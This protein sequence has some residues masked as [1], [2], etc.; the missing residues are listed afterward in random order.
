[1]L[2][3]LVGSEMCIRDRAQCA[4][5]FLPYVRRGND[6]DLCYSIPVSYL[7]ANATSPNRLRAASY[8]EP[9]SHTPDNMDEECVVAYV[10]CPA[11]FDTFLHVWE[12][13]LRPLQLLHQEHVLPTLYVVQGPPL[14]IPDGS[15]FGV[16]TSANISPKRAKA[17]P[18][19][20]PS[21]RSKSPIVMTNIHTTPQARRQMKAAL[22]SRGMDADTL[23]DTPTTGTTTP[24]GFT[25]EAHANTPNARKAKALLASF[26]P[27]SLI[28]ISEPT[29]LLSISYAVFCLKKK[30]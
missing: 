16:N 29:R 9:S 2:R 17:V 28:H 19:R 30:K 15:S 21:D 14:E 7:D 4:A 23:V 10:R 20:A 27:L 6:V 25:P 11:S 24:G 3:S 22:P 13:C 1:M 18:S 8:V 12:E 26:V 5:T